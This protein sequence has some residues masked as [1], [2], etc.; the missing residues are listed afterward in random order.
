MFLF[1]TCY[2]R[3]CVHHRRLRFLLISSQL[4]HCRSALV[5]LNNAQ[6]GF[7]FPSVFPARRLVK[8][9]SHF[10]HYWTPYLHFWPQKPLS[11]NQRIKRSY[12]LHSFKD[13]W[14][15]RTVSYLIQTCTLPT[16]FLCLFLCFKLIPVKNWHVRTIT[17][18]FSLFH[19]CEQNKI[20]YK[21]FE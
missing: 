5:R 1:R 7:S 15:F 11:S 20:R 17:M 9:P 3:P 6:S 8:V 2:F 12:I 4:Q 18:F 14:Y 13:F 21:S 19:I 16:L 10:L